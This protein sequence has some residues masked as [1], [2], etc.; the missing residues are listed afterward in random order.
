MKDKARPKKPYI[1][2][3]ARLLVLTTIFVMI[4]EV[5][6]YV[7]SIA[8]FRQ[9]W[10]EERL[11]AAQIAALALVA[12]SDY[13]VSDELA[14]E[15]LENAEVQAVV[16][17]R[18][19]NRK[20]ILGDD[21]PLNITARYDLRNANF[22]SLIMDAFITMRRNDDGLIEVTGNARQN[23]GDY[24]QIILKEMPLAH[25]MYIHTRNIVFLSLIISFITASLVYLALSWLMVRP[26]RR[27]TENVVSFRDKPE[28]AT[29]IIR[30]TMRS[31]EIGIVQRELF[32]MQ[33]AVR[34]ALRQKT[35]L[36]HIGAAVAKIN[37][38]LR[39][40]LSSANLI[41][42]RLSNIDDPT[43][44]ALA[45]RLVHS[46]DRAAELCEKTIE[47]ARSDDMPHNRQ[48]VALLSIC[49][50]IRL[51]LGLNPEN[52]TAEGVEFIIDVAPGHKVVADPRQLYRVLLNICK[53][54]QQ[55][56][57]AMP[58]D[59][60]RKTIKI[61][62]FLENNRVNFEIEDTGPGMPAAALAHIYEPFRGSARSGGTGLGLAIARE[63]LE[64]N[65]GRID[66]VRSDEN[67][68][69]FHLCLPAPAKGHHS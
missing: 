54:S 6:I 47:Y 26:I 22:L 19:D 42:D 57:E 29:R 32:E 34:T 36:A 2:L 30:P 11:A 9:T 21:M 13:M 59:H 52:S 65:G 44:Q 38:D 49:E 4:A 18:E 64:A 62:S 66:L 23:A 1:G 50:D 46:I 56:L 3:S 39:N 15:L 53:N 63:L 14:K 35:R 25:A 40:I 31:D 7:P 51:S 43:V 16:L 20:L 61:R 45:P 55:V 37:H 41:S 24:V 69:C 67:G 48:A 17:K 58:P 68:T 10:L 33:G 60:H 5:L 12:T 8:Y 27:I 28:D